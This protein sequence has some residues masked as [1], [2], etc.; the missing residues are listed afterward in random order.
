[1]TIDPRIGVWFSIVA[2]ILSVLVGA[3]AELTDIFGA[4]I[5]HKTVAVIVLVNAV[6][7]GVNAVLHMIPSQ[8]PNADTQ[9]DFW[10]GPKSPLG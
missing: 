6:I 5:A 1:M 7:N 9:K 8:Q 4:E 3:T 10:L 2:A